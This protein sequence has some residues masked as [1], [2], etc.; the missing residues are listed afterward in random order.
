MNSSNA[1]KARQLP[2]PLVERSEKEIAQMIKNRVEAI[3]AVKGSHQ[4]SVRMTGKR[5]DV[6]MHLLLDSD[7]RLEDVH[8]ITSNVDREV[9]KVVPNARVT[10]QTEP[11]G[12]DKRN[13]GRMIK[14]IAEAVPGSRGVH[15]IHIQKIGG[16]LCIDL[17]LEVGANSTLKQA[18]DISDEV[19]R[20]LK[21]A[22]LNISEI[23]IHMESAS[24]LIS[25][26]LR[27]EASELRWYIEHAADHFPEIKAIDRVRIRKI[28]DKTH[29]VLRCLFDRSI[30]V[31]Q[32]HEILNKLENMIRNAFPD[33][34]RIDVHEEPA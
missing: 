34:D 21:I 30:T 23:V 24:D 8:K 9:R 32:A 26:E 2:I 18:H 33:I 27:G 11:L 17:H 20:R 6:D 19:E 28:G 13:L 14:E 15:N 3:K 29:V 7:L 16:R 10:V 5:F 4:I 31:K 1:R 25:N 22:N 12:G